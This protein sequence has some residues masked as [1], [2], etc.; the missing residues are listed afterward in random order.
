MYVGANGNSRAPRSTGGHPRPLLGSGGRL[1]ESG[2]LLPHDLHDRSQHGCRFART[3]AAAYFEV[4]RHAPGC[5]TS[6][7]S[8]PEKVAG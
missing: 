2:C 4:H 7:I 1:R 8:V 5:S 3:G 6:S